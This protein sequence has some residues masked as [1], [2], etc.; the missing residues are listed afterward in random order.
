MKFPVLQRA[1]ARFAAVASLT[2]AAFTLASPAGAQEKVDV[3]T[4]ERI[5]SEALERSQVMDIMSWLTDVHGPRLSWS[6]T[7]RKAADWTA[8]TMK[9]WGLANVHLEPWTTPAGI[10]W[11]NERFSFMAVS[12]NPFIVDAVPRAWSAGTNGRVSG[13]PVRIQV[14]CFAELQQKYA[15]QLRG[16]FIMPTAPT[17]NPV[18]EFNSYAARRT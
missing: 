11:Q 8:E 15:G 9:S 4:I 18:T 13:A 16:K 2:T 12:P 7:S 3:A 10:G 14:D 1:N 17:A 5:K 6:P